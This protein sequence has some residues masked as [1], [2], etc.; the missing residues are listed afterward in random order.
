MPKSGTL[1]ICAA[2]Q[3]HSSAGFAFPDLF[4]PCFL[5]S[6]ARRLSPN[7]RRAF[8]FQVRSGNS[9]AN[10]RDWC[11][12]SPGIAA[13]FNSQGEIMTAKQRE[14][15]VVMIV[16]GIAELEERNGKIYPK[17]RRI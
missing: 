8:S 16:A 11:L 4:R 6:T 15:L 3:P 17:G 7:Q 1:L 12:S 10:P 9:V 5:P 14:A 2:R 13:P